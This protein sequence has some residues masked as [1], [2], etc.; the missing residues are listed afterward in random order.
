MWGTTI[1][2]RV[3]RAG[4]GIRPVCACADG[5]DCGEVGVDEQTRDPGFDDGT[6]FS[7][8]V[9][10]PE[11]R[12][13]RRSPGLASLVAERRRLYDLLDALPDMICVLDPDHYPVFSNAH[14]RAQFGESEGRQCHEFIWGLSE[15]C[16]FCR[17]FGVLETG[18]AQHWEIQRDDGR[19]IALHNYPFADID[20]SPLVIE[21][22]V[23]I[24]ERRR[25]ETE[26]AGHRERLEEL[27]QQRTSD[28]Q[29]AMDRFKSLFVSSPDAIFITRPDG[30]IMDANPTASRV[31]GWTLDELRSVGRSALLDDADP[32]LK[33]AL[34]EQAKRGVVAGREVT[35]IRR[36]GERFTVEVDSVRLPGEERESFIIARDITERRRAERESLITARALDQAEIGVVRTD[37][38]G[39]INLVNDALTAA[40]GYTRDELLGSNLFD[41]AVG[42]DAQSWP[43]RWEHVKRVH[44]ESFERDFRSKDGGAVPMRVS[45]TMIEV[46][47]KEFA[48]TFIRSTVTRR[49]PR[50]RSPR[51]TNNS[52][53]ARRWRP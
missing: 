7:W 19:T 12:R 30:A 5:G 22:G 50:G 11:P 14:F 10:D 33:E 3:T 13:A 43:A 28:L 52:A 15:P 37:E 9:D 46:D 25:V 34:G 32:R 41:L 6:L 2:K 31:F 53:R 24:T 8:P 36:S 47:G 20:G 29:Q 38:Q 4:T 17:A 21:I 40:L 51:A 44:T 45:L 35:A 23:D 49:P 26:L 27:V 1:I 16:E 39:R 42:L 18:V 48:N